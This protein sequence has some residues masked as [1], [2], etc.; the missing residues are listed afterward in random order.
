MGRESRRRAWATAILLIPAAV[1]LFPLL[2]LVSMSFK[3]GGEVMAYPPRLLPNSLDWSNYAAALRAA[4]LARFLLNSAVVA[5]A[6]TALQVVTSVLAAFALARMEFRG[7]ALAFALVVA[8]MLVPGEVTLIPNYFTLARLDWIDTYAG[9]IVPFSASGFG[10]FLLY[11]FFRSI[12]KELEEAATLDGASRLRFL[13]QIAVPLSMP[14]VL[15]FGVYAFINAWNMYLWPLAVTQST[16]MQTAQIGLGMFRS[17]NESVSWGVI[18]AATTI[19]IS[20]T[21]LLFAATQKQF[22][23]GITMSGLKG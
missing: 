3:V 13:V 17:Q 4:P 7:K 12:P 16:A 1:Q 11:Q 15:A 10:I 9:L 20:P 2:Y 5:C 22:V 14:A 8:T 23:R 6:I 19:L 18:M 21:V